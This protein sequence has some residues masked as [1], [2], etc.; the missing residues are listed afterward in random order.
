MG[1]YT[2]LHDHLTVKNVCSPWIPHNLT[3]SLKII[4][5]CRLVQTNSMPLLEKTCITLKQ[6]MNNSICVGTKNRS[7]QLYE[8]FKKKHCSLSHLENWSW[9]DSV[10]RGE[11]RKTNKF[12]WTLLH[13][14]N[15]S[16]HISRRRVRE[17]TQV[18]T[19]PYMN[20]PI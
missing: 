5:L 10:F 3:K 19:S 17:T 14:D 7:A 6:L 12:C 20:L 8:C 11:T 4:L 16:C 1:I 9:G 18:C 2:I 13:E 15:A